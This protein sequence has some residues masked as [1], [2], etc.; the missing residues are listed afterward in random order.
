MA[1]SIDRKAITTAEIRCTSGCQG[2]GT[3]HPHAYGS[4]SIVINKQVA[5]SEN[6]K[7]DTL[8]TNH[9]AAYQSLIEA[10]KYVQANKGRS[11]LKWFVHVDSVL[12]LRQLAGE[13]QIRSPKLSEQC[14]EARAILGGLKITFA[15]GAPVSAPTAEIAP[16]A[17]FTV[18]D[19][20]F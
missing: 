7:F 19:C 12:V 17:E 10:L 3:D 1:T 13:W 6:L 14:K 18:D 5:Y 20:P 16:K 15:N 2:N 8:T 11:S 9:E 4:F